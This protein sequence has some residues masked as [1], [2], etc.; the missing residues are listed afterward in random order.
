LGVVGD[1]IAQVRAPGVWSLLFQHNGVNAV[2]VPLHVEPANLPAFFDGVRRLRNLVGL[3]VTIPHKPVVLRWVD[4]AS[5]RAAQVGACNAVVVESSGRTR[6]DM[7]DGVGF[8]AGLREAGQS[9]RGRRALLVGSG[10]V[11]SAIAFG[12]AEAGVDSVSVSDVIAERAEA[13]SARLLAA[14]YR[15]AVSAPDPA[16]FDLVVNA[17]P[18][19]MHV[20]DPLPFDCSRLD[21]TAIVGDVVISHEQEVTPLVVAAR[22]RGCF[23]QPGTVMTDHQ[24]AEMARFFGFES[25]DWSADT[26]ARLTR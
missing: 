16:G 14:G 19:G 2:C 24:I 4:E 13:L 25:G 23:V 3:I 11:G 9:V 15:S 18:A 12:L 21:A 8:V 6:G 5:P 10:G 7:F 22:E 17:S 1:P 26:I 20:G